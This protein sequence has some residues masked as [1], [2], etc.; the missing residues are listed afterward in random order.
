MFFLLEQVL[1]LSLLH[2][3][4]YEKF[5]FLPYISTVPV[6]H[7]G[8]TSISI[9]NWPSFSIDCD[10]HV[11]STTQRRKTAHTRKRREKTQQNCNKSRFVQRN[12]GAQYN[13]QIV[14]H[15]LL[16][17][18]SALRPAGYAAESRITIKKPNSGA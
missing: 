6:D 12:A 13:M 3:H 11:H 4:V 8:I 2:S 7:I 5:E 1:R 14:G 9:I 17:E 16:N 10:I 15:N 18:I